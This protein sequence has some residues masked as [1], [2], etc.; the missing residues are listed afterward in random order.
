MDK[1]ELDFFYQTMLRLI[2]ED[3]NNEKVLD[4]KDSH[5]VRASMDE[6]LPI[7]GTTIEQVF[8]KFENSIVPNLNRNTDKKYGAFIT[9]S[10]THISIVAEAVKA[11][12][13]QNMLKWIN[14]PAANELEAI[15]IDWIAEFLF[16]RQIKYGM[17]TS[18]GSMSNF[19]A[20]HFALSE[21]YPE[22]ATSGVGNHQFKIYCS[23]ESHSSI[24]RAA[25]FLGLG[26]SCVSAIPVDEHQRIVVR[27]L[28]STIKDDIEK[29]FTPLAVIGNAGTTNTGAIDSLTELGQ[30]AQKYNAWFHV[31][32]AYGLPAIRIER[33]KHKFDGVEMADSISINPHKWLFV[34]FE[35]SA[36]LLK[37]EPRDIHENPEYLEDI[38]DTGN[39]TAKHTIELT[40]EFRALKV[41]FTLKYF[42]VEKIVSFI[43]NDIAMAN[44]FSDQ[45]KGTGSFETIKQELSIVCFRYYSTDC[46][47]RQ[48]DEINNALLKKITVEGKVFVTGTKL[49]G[50]SYLRIY[51]GNPNRTEVDV[52]EVVQVILEGV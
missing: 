48:L 36:I 39:E 18:G 9:G 22:R 19:L 14:S 17:L 30:I 38:V 1:H 35:S 15:V 41:W 50:R 32:G 43:E 10:G 5:A 37:E 11:R 4:L 34:N 31:D 21:H 3:C 40:K 29:G 23:T 7:H 51:F 52:D 16:A 2:N 45:L 26:R 8:S 12:Y 42:G 33:L 6:V 24:P 13:N 46:S 20:L 28:E 44:Y 47:D 27:E 49:R 25:V